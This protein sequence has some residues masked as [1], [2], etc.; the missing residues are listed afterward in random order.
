MYKRLGVIKNKKD[1]RKV[2][3]KL[4][5]KGYKWRMGEG[6]TCSEMRAIL[7]REIRQGRIVYIVADDECAKS[8]LYELVRTPY[9]ELAEDEV[10]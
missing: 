10:F 9:K 5:K 8:V 6:L 2:L 1:V 4:G 3:N 7:R